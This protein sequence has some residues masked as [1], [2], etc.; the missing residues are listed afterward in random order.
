MDELGIRRTVREHYA[1]A[2]ESCCGAEAGGRC[3]SATSSGAR[4]G[5]AAS[6]VPKMGVGDPVTRL[7]PRLGET[8]VD[9]GSGPGSDVL[10][11]A[12]LVGPAGRA[13]GVDATAEMV[14]RARAAAQALG[15]ENAEFRLGEIE[16]LPIES[17]T[18]D[19]ITSDCVVNLSPDKAQVF[20]EAFRVLKPGGRIVVSDVVADQTLPP[21]AR[22]DSERWAACEAGAVT[23]EDYVG[24]MQAAGFREVV[25]ERHGVYRRGLSRATVQGVKPRTPS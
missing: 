12:T 1:A 16:H 18:V 23:L 9:L 13:I 22:Q 7:A 25:A 15:R 11:V 19:G 21:E 20:R 4:V 3:G 6:L 17:G 14:Y 10:G 2:S 5:D 8:V 24:L